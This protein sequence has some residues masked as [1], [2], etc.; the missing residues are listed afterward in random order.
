MAAAFFSA[1]ADPAR[2][3]AI[4]AGTQPGER[5]HA[6]VVDVMREI[7]IDLSDKR[8]QRLTEDLARSASL[9]ITMG[10]GD[11]CPYVPGLTR[12]DWPLID[13]KSLPTSQV[14]RIRDEIRDR[15]SALV[16]AHGWRRMAASP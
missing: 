9:L 7:G 1:F 3:E 6:E 16:D 4:S 10:C 15:V 13:P 2:A 14:R 8:P 12:D 5:V 11:E